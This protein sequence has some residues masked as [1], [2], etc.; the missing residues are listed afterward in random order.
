M[1]AK[2]ERAPRRSYDN[3]RAVRRKPG[4]GTQLDRTAKF[5][6]ERQL[7]CALAGAAC[8]ILLLPDEAL[9]YIFQ[10]GHPPS[11]L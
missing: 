5:E 1:Y 10:L 9:C 8:F 2:D 3:S 7:A 6:D 4:R 11:S